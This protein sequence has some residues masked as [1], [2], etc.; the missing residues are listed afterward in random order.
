MSGS[1]VRVQFYE[2][3]SN[4][5]EED[6]FSQQTLKSMEEQ[7]CETDGVKDCGNDERVMTVKTLIVNEWPD[8]C[9]MT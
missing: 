1:P 7:I 6:R 2:S 5:L 3:Q 4:S 9:K 8:M